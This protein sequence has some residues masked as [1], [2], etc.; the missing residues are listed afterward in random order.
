[1][2]SPVR[3]DG[4]PIRAEPARVVAA[5]R[6]ARRFYR[7]HLAQAE[8][9]RRYLANRGLGVLTHPRGAGAPWHLGYAPR[10]WTHLVDHLTRLGYTPNELLAAGLA[11]RTRRGRILDTFRDRIMFPIHNPNG[12]PVAFIGR[13]AP[14]A[15]AHVPK[16][17]NSTDTPTYH[18]GQMLYGVG[19][20]A[21]RIA[22]GAAPVLVEGPVDVLAIWLT[23]PDPAS[24]VAV[25]ACGTGLT[26]D[27]IA[28]IAAMPGAA[29]HGVTVAFDNDPAGWRGTERAWYLLSGNA[30]THLYAA[31]LPDGL[32]PGDLL[33]SRDGVKALRSAVGAH[34]RPLAH[35]V[36]DLGLHRLTERNPE[37][38]TFVEGRVAAARTLTSLLTHL[39]ADQ[40][41]ALIGYIAQR[42][43]TGLE[44][45]AE[46][47]IAHLERP[48]TIQ[49]T[50]S[51]PE[52]G[53]DHPG[54]EVASTP[55]GRP[56][57][58]PPL[59]SLATGPAPGWQASPDISTPRRTR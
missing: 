1:M 46:A 20:Q 13:A 56:R 19:E 3:Y 7:R 52:A 21:E 10:G 55:P 44:T 42:T 48:P 53:A 23:H 16:Y 2:T 50:S 22:A 5:H 15:P 27:H 17:I 51:P 29:R 31:I 39:P 43:N 38:L 11:S 59:G 49:S 26:A 54:V 35:A 4:G 9:P 28:S 37:L 36:V 34:A 24:R 18:K 30:G 47:V 58:F 57:S 45:V 40:I 41:T 8:G 32:D 25:A 6:E 12:E 14:T 33:T